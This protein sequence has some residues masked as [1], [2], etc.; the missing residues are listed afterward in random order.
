MINEKPLQSK[1][2]LISLGCDKNTVDSE[3]MLGILS[4]HG[5]LL[6]DDPAEAEAV[7]VNTCCFIRDAL[8]ESIST[9]FEMAELKKEGSLRFLIVA[10][11]MSQR[12]R[13]EISD[14]IPEVDAFVGTTS[15]PK[16]AEVLD[17]LFGGEENV[18]IFLDVNRVTEESPRVHATEKPYVGYLKIA[19]GCDKK[20]TYCAIPQFRGSYRSIPMN[21]LVKTASELAKDGVKELILVAQETTV[22]G[23]D[24]YGK[25]SLPE[26]L[27]RLSGIEDLDWIR[28]LYCYPEEIDEEL[29]ETI[30]K[31][32]KVLHY[33]DM[34]LQHTEDHVLQRMGRRLSKKKLY[35]LV[36]KLR[37]RIPDIT[38]RTTLIT[39]FPG[40]TAEEHA[41]VMDTLEELEFDHLGVFTYSR[42]E[43]T[44]AAGFPDQI[45]EDVKERYREEIMELQQEISFSKNEKLIG[46]EMDMII[47]GYLPDEEVYVGRTYRDAPDVDGMVFAACDRE[48]ISG[49]ILTVRITEAA[50]YDLYAEPVE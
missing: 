8:E 27:R 5:Y 6:T 21:R 3:E 13:D 36:H 42:E 49:S 48:L 31:T 35:D 45:E 50:E 33:I 17:R 38:L 46:Q 14:E 26:L 4:E 37:E 10:G 15:F 40:E 47:E 11:C 44:I 32:P 12:Y 24:I 43:G 25:K 41:A 39:G 30:A 20:C 22:Y 1:I 9:V 7:I 19:E 34:P 29:I 2:A 28:I 16:I 18:E 23:K